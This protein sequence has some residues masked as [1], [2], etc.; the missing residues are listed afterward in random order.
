MEDRKL[1]ILTTSA[2]PHDWTLFAATLGIHIERGDEA[3]VCIVTHGGSTQREAWLDEL[4]KPEAERD[5]AIINEPVEKYIDQK[6]DE[7]RQAAAIFG[8]T[9]VRFLNFPDKPFL[10]ERYPEAI[11]TITELILEVRPHVMITENPFTSGDTG[12]ADAHRNDH[13]E[14]GIAT[15]EAKDRAARPRGGSVVAPHNVATTFWAAHDKNDLDFAIELTDEWF[16]KRVQAELL[17]ETQG[18]NEAWAR[19]R[20]ELE[21]GHMGWRMRTE[22]A[23][24]FAREKNELLTHLPVPERM[25]EMSEQGAGAFIDRVSG[26]ARAE[27]QRS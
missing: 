15:L 12:R 5:P 7:M 18:H 21:V 24:G 13:T 16:E 2:H 23:E 1:R 25:I 27:A 3:T 17:Y 11:D 10:I 9:D 8:V 6:A 14:V 19:R 20:M 4:R 26:K 22:Y